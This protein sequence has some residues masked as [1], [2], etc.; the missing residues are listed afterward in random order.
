MDW[1]L[2]VRGDV[3]HRLFTGSGGRGLR[4]TPWSSGPVREAGTEHYGV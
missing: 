3:R 1:P 4:Q 2:L